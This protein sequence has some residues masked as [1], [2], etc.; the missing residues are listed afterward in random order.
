MSVHKY[1]GA[2]D[3]RFTFFVSRFNTR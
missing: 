1:A 3:N 2:V